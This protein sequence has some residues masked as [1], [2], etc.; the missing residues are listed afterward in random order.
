MHNS[1]F[2]LIAFYFLILAGMNAQG[3]HDQEK[4]I[5]QEKKSFF[6]GPTGDKSIQEG[7]DFK[8]I[9]FQWDLDPALRQIGG[10]IT[11]YYE[12]IDQ[13]LEIMNLQL[14]PDL[15]VSDISY[16]GQTLTA[17]HDGYALNIP[18]PLSVPI[19]T[20]DSISITYAGVPPQTGFGSFEQD[21]ANH[22]PVLWTL[23]EPEGAPDWWPCKKDLNDKIDSIDYY[24]SVPIGNKVASNGVLVSVTAHQTN[25]I[26][27][28]K[29]RY[30]IDYYLVC[31]ATT[32]YIEI[33][34]TITFADQTKMPL[35]DMAYPQNAAE[36]SQSMPYLKNQILFFSDMFGKYPFAKEKYGHAQFGWGGGMEH[37][38]M[39]FM[40]NLSFSLTA[41]ELAHQWFGDKVTCCSWSDIW[42]NEGFATFLASLC[43]E[44][45]YPN[46]YLNH[47]KQIFDNVISRP[48]GTV[49]VPEGGDV[50]RIFSGRL[51]YNKG[52]YLLH[53][54]RWE[55][56]DS[57]FFR[58]IRHYINDPALSY[59][60]A[61]TDDLQRV[62]ENESGRD[63]SD[64]F[65]VW[66]EGQGYPIYSIKWSQN[67]QRLFRFE[68]H[69]S[70]SDAS[71]PFFAMHLPVLVQGV[72]DDSL[73]VFNQ[74]TTDQIFE[75]QLPFAVD[76]IIFDPRYDILNT[77]EIERVS[78][79]KSEGKIISALQLSPNPVKNVFTFNLPVLQA[80]KYTAEIISA[81]GDTVST[82]VPIAGR[83]EINIGY[84]AAGTYV[85]YV[86]TKDRVY[87][88]K[89]IKQ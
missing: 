81:N 36:W 28:W 10:T 51:T 5:D 67:D 86:Y 58:G 57:T 88:G 12:V 52:S 37:Q 7:F 87:S 73:L 78:A 4:L 44:R 68:V 15:S 69:Q 6:K 24:I 25:N 48:N 23:S 18:M 65:K 84:L 33:K 47:K 71:V 27:H 13:P 45:F 62:L 79:N 83:N 17:T 3:I 53:M 8:Y 43:Q 35:L 56:G 66:F 34:D 32:N 63:L 31:F 49:K 38:T 55:L 14:A 22:G 76:T 70:T 29:H 50:N 77:H 9:R 42:L 75:V 20:K 19:G 64:F 1:I 89:I 85:I 74:M 59:G 41:H 60:T 61:C 16:H 54:L 30:P 80:E 39:S 26:Y 2:L 21:N 82:F 46:T 72:N 40:V 11:Y